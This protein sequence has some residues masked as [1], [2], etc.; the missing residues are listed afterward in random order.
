MDHIGPKLSAGAISAEVL[1]IYALYCIVDLLLYFKVT[2]TVPVLSKVSNLEV[3]IMNYKSSK[4]LAQDSQSCAIL[5][6]AVRALGVQT[7]Q[8]MKSSAYAAFLRIR[9][10][11]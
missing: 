1:I 2:L 8:V 9:A 5:G 3:K 7:C 11:Q 6:Y 10:Q 4:A